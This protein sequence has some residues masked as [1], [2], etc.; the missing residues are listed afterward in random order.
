MRT[1][2]FWKNTETSFLPS[3]KFGD[4]DRV[5]KFQVC[6]ST[7]LVYS[8]PVPNQASKVGETEV[9]VSVLFLKESSI[10][11]ICFELRLL[12]C[13]VVASNDVPRKKVSLVVKLFVKVYLMAEGTSSFINCAFTYSY[14]IRVLVDT[15]T[16]QNNNYGLRCTYY[17][18]SPTSSSPLLKWLL[19]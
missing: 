7:T 6:L 1:N 11:T 2:L 18:V 19:S 15:L 8:N 9:F 12:R 10:K 13:K 5:S 4:D 17:K 16:C 3:L 14:I